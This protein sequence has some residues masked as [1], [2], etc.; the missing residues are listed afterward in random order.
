MTYTVTQSGDEAFPYILTLLSTG[1]RYFRCE[2][3]VALTI[4]LWTS[5]GFVHVH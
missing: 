5:L 1:E 3:T 2:D 4:T